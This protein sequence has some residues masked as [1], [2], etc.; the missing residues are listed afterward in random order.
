MYGADRFV[1]CNI[2]NVGLTPKERQ[3]FLRRKLEI[4]V[5]SCF[6]SSSANFSVRSSAAALHHKE[7]A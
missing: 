5:I 3:E 1:N 7:Y 4:T 6:P 2:E